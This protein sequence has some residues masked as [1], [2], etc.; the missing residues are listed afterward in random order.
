M[1]FMRVIARKNLAAFSVKHPETRPVL[2]RWEAV[3]KAASWRTMSELQ[4]SFSNAVVSN[5]ERVKFE[6]HHNDY[7]MIVVFDFVRQVAF[8][9]FLGTHKE[10]DAVNAL[11]VSMF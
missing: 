8:I 10:Y 3:V 7:R 1:S 5:S 11:T 4:A 9:K 6:V 2:E